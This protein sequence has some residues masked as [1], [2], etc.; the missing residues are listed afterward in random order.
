MMITPH[1]LVGAALAMKISNPF[2]L[3]FFA[4]VSHFVIDMIPHHDY[5]IDPFKKKFYKMLIDGVI[6]GLLLW[7]FVAHLPFEQQVLFVLG[8]FFAI[9][10]DGLWMLHRLFSWKFLEPYVSIHHKLHWLIIQADNKAHPV[11]G[12]A[13]Q[14]VVV[15]LSLYVL[16]PLLV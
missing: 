7:Y 15:A 14:A 9:F 4:F 13:T 16:S 10:P 11:I 1:V 8:G 3:V 5:D 2:T 12:L 6:A